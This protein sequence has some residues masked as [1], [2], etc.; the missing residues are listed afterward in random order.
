MPSKYHVIDIE[1]L[2]IELEVWHCLT[3]INYYENTWIFCSNHISHTSEVKN[4]TCHIRCCG[5][6]NYAYIWSE[7]CFKVSKIELKIRIE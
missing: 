4:S 2:Y 5:Q 1:S 7:L 3:P 6:S